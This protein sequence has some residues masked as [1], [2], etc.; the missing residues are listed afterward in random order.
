M[1]NLND[2]FD[3]MRKDNK[4]STKLELSNGFV[5]VSIDPRDRHKMAFTIPIG[6]FQF[7]RMSFGSKNALFYFQR[8]M[9]KVLK[10]LLGEGVMVYPDDMYL[11]AAKIKKNTWIYCKKL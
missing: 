10:P 2:M 8:V 5:Q 9:T 4:Y 6:K 3:K 1:P 7:E 11:S